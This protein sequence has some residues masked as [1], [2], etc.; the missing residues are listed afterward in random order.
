MK[1]IEKSFRVLAVMVVLFA[2]F[3]LVGCDN[4]ETIMDV[5]TPGGGV[6]I[7]RDRTTGEMTV[8]VDQ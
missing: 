2:G 1:S 5:N 7:E 4:K 8:D 6:E 3:M